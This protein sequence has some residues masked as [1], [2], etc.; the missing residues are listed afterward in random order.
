MEGVR[1]YVLSIVAASLISGIVLGFLQ[2]GTLKQL[3]KMICGLFLAFMVIGPIQR[4]D[5]SDFQI[6][7]DAV[8]EGSL[9]TEEGEE[10]AREAL[11]EIIKSET[12]AYIL[13]K[14]A[15]LDL[16]LN[17]TVRV[18][19]GD[20]PLPEGVRISGKVSPYA[21]TRL[22]AAITSELGIPKENVEWTG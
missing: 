6:P 9:Y 17:V 16:Q 11:V 3:L 1:Q 10:I 12:E 14:A 8:T 7:G 22:E 21:R 20:P 4:L 2:G 18:S 5:I 19:D 15:A 13:D